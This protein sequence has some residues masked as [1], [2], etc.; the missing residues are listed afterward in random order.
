MMRTDRQH[1]AHCEDTP[2][3]RT[4]SD[5]RFVNKAR[6]ALKMVWLGARAERVA[7]GKVRVQRSMLWCI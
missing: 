7:S 3:R 4:P 5:G 2:V 6:T 1:R